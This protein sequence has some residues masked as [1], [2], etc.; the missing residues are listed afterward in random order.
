MISYR[1]SKRKR[2]QQNYS[3]ALA[4]LLEGEEILPATLRSGIWIRYNLVATR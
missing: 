1:S 4:A 2:M 3:H